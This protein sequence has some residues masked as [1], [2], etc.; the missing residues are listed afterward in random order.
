[1]SLSLA[2]T[3]LTY[4]DIAAVHITNQ[5]ETTVVW[6]KLTGTPAA[7]TSVPAFS[8]FF[9]P[10]WRP[11]ARGALLGLTRYV[12][13]NHS[14]RAALEAT[15]YQTHQIMDAMNADAGVDLAELRVDGGM[16][17]NELLMQPQADQLGVEDIRPRITE[18]T[19]LGAAFATGIAIS[20]WESEREVIA[21]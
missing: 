15:A 12:T 1:V 11:D 7:P 14:A 13:K 17:A 4:Q 20:Y 16:V 21:T 3:N 10:C 6:N 8:G 5:R 2:G 9:A 19:A 18:T